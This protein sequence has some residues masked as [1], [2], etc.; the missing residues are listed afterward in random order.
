MN[1]VL[2]IDVWVVMFACKQRHGCLRHVHR[3]RKVVAGRDLYV[4]HVSGIVFII[5]KTIYNILFTLLA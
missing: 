3:R 4:L 5:F 2:L 1:T